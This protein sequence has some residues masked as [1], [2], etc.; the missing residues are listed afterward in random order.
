[1]ELI[2]CDKLEN[3][4]V[5]VIDLY[6]DRKIGKLFIG[7]FQRGIFVYDM[8]IKSVT[9]PERNLKD[10]S[11]TQFKPLNDKE[12]LVATDGGG[13]HKI[14][15]E[16]YLLEPY[17]ITD[18]NSNNGMNG[19]SINDIYVDDEERIWLANYPIG[20]TI[21]NNRYPSYKWIKHSIGNKQS[22]IND[23]VNAV[24]ED[25]DGRFVVRN[26]QW[27]QLLQFKDRPMEF[28][29]QFF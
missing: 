19:N 27:Y 17:I 28:G 14:N 7:T 13:V 10:I 3:Q 16:N 22:L 21:R 25:R 9:Q 2:D 5:Q 26:K 1:M 12:L 29:P 6:F 18:Y 23:Q 11:I 4:K 15:T 24:I 8:S 20:I